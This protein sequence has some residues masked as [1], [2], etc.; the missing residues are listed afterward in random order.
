MM[1]ESLF[2]QRPF[3]H[4][5]R[6]NILV[7]QL[8]GFLRHERRDLRL[9]DRHSTILY[10]SLQELVPNAEQRP[11]AVPQITGELVGARRESV[12]FR[13][14]ID[15]PDLAMLAAR[16]G[17]RN[18]AGGFPP[19]AGLAPPAQYLAHDVALAAPAERLD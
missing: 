17:L 19:A 18:V 3:L 11:H 5:R 2:H 4:A 1:T 7:E 10:E 8:L 13:L 14:C 6:T 16:P 12:G 9:H 15:A